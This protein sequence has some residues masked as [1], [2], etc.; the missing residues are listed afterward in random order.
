M[1]ALELLRTVFWHW[2]DKTTS[3]DGCWIWTGHVRGNGYGTIG[4]GYKRV[5]AHRLSWIVNCGN[6]PDEKQVCHVCD[7][8]ICVRPDHLLLGDCSGKRGGQGS[9]GQACPFQIT[10]QVR[11]T[12]EQL[13]QHAFWMQVDK[14]TNP[15]GCWDWTGKLRLH[16]YGV[17]NVG[18]KAIKAHRLSWLVNHGDLPV[19][20]LVCHTCDNPKCV[21]PDHLFLGTPA[22]NA[23]DMVRK[24]RHR[25]GKRRSSK[26]ATNATPEL[27]CQEIIE[28]CRGGMTFKAIAKSVNLHRSTVSSICK[29]RGEHSRVYDIV[30]K[31]QVGTEVQK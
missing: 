10:S 28:L 21:R 20:K 19:D 8:P 26:G 11:M 27:L 9:Q 3:P 4:I 16:G 2:V 12:A 15:H 25:T 17:M 22:E 6:L 24:G 29:K 5:K 13:L 18:H 30:T 31:E 7:N 23:A 1:T 14:S